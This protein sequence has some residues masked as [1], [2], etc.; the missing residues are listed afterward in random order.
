MTRAWVHPHRADSLCAPDASVAQGIERR[1]PVPKVA[2]SNPAGGTTRGGSI[3]HMPGQTHS[4]VN[5]LLA[6][7]AAG[8]MVTTDYMLG[9]MRLQRHLAELGWALEIVTR[10]DGLVTRSRNAFASAVVRDERFSHLLM[11]DADISAEPETVARLVNFGE[12]LVGA[13]VPLRHVL[14]DR[15]AEQA[16]AVSGSSAAELAS[17]SQTYAVTFESDAADRERDGFAPAIAVGSGVMLVSRRAL[18]SIAEAGQ[19]AR[20]EQAAGSVDGD[21]SGWGFFDPI[22]TPDGTYL[23]EDY[24]LCHRWREMGNSVWADIHARTRHVG[25]VPISGDMFASMQAA[26]RRARG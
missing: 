11:I 9:V 23:S 12:D 16:S 25:P 26:E 8:G 21:P 20:F 17:A 13:C 5:I 1:F 2:G 3:P 22:I 10:A 14:W 7:P 15:V 4:A 6:T 24:A 18:I 19:A